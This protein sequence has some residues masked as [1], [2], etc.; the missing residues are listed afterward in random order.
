MKIAYLGTYPP[1]ECG[2][3]TFTQD[4]VNAINNKTS[5]KTAAD[6]IAINDESSIYN[7]DKEVRYQI[8]QHDVED[9]IETAKRINN[10]P[11]IQLVNIQH[12]FGLFGGECGEYI[13]PFLESLEK[14]VVVTFHSV[15]PNP[16]E[17]LKKVVKAI[18]E[19]TKGIIVMANSAKGIL[20]KYYKVDKKKIFKIHHGVPDIENNIDKDKLKKELRLENK[21]V[22]LTFGM[23][24]KGKGIEY[25]IK[26]LPKIVKKYPDVLYLVV[27]ETHPQVRKHEG[28]RYRNQLLKLVDKLGLK[29][30]VKFYNKYLPIGE[31]IKFLQA[32]DI[33]ITPSLD[34]NQIVSGTLAYALSSGTPV[35]ATKY[36]HAKELITS[37]RG[38]LVNFEDHKEIEEALK[39]LIEN[40]RLRSEMGKNSYDYGRN[41]VW[42]NVAKKH[43]KL[44]RKISKNKD[45][46]YSLPEIKLNHLKTLTDTTGIIQH[47]KHSVP[48]RSSGYTLDDNT[49]ALIVAAKH[50][51][52][53]KDGDDLNL[54]NIYLAFIKHAQKE[55]GNFYITMHY[56]NEFAKDEKSED[57][58]GRALWACGVLINSTVYDNIK[59]NAKFV[60]DNA[61]KSLNKIESPRAIAFS[62]LGLAEY[63]NKYKQNNLKEK[64]NFLADKLLKLYNKESSKDWR[65]FEPYL[66]YSNGVLPEAMFK[67]YDIL[68]EDEYLNV[69]KESLDFLKDIT[70]VKDK[71][72]LIG[73][74]GWYR[75]NGKRAMYDQQPVDACSLVRAFL[76]A[77]NSTKDKE[78]YKNTFFSFEWFLGRNSLNRRIY[79]DITGGSFDGLNPKEINL[80]Q[81]AESTISYLMARLYIEKLK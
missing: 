32:A 37:N 74:D 53:T 8:N 44:F 41:M 72:V 1:R 2:I 70:F 62:I 68:K 65:W 40:D 13:I 73:H 11:E 22:L 34:P 20:K 12:E 64:I 50:Y 6:I 46:R 77:Y 5:P 47:A 14:P 3:A 19:R 71:V 15:L 25:A 45:L 54:I 4:L 29:N 9:Y 49:R 69:A 39:F 28:E 57:S 56:N 35:I 7:Y 79:D 76:A 78:Y 58:Y 48:D 61:L 75:K 43:I 38:I 52:L 59:D 18:A 16:D 67:S 23:L 63:Y 21:F 51:D 26:A 66:T 80:N 24:S 36:I 30:N 10:N 17:K 42:D 31:I 60:L 81:G 55:N 33:Y 27:G